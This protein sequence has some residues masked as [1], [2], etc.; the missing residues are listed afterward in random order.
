M[1]FE[2]LWIIGGIT[3]G[4]LSFRKIKKDKIGKKGLRGVYTYEP[5]FSI[6][7]LAVMLLAGIAVFSALLGIISCILKRFDK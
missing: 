5:P 3:L 7:E 2:C 4:I 1:L 6:H